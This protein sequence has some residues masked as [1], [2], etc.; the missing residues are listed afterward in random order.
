MTLQ[1]FEPP[2]QDKKK[3]YVI[4]WKYI[5]VQKI[6]ESV[7]NLSAMVGVKWCIRQ[8]WAWH[9]LF[10]QENVQKRFQFQ[11]LDTLYYALQCFLFCI[12]QVIL[13]PT[14]NSSKSAELHQ[15][16][17]PKNSQDSDLKIKLAVRMDKPPHM[18]HSGWVYAWF[19]FSVEILDFILVYHFWKFTER[20]RISDFYMDF[21][22]HPQMT[23]V[24]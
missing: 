16:I 19:F 9:L 22:P 11:L 14:S 7:L 13:Y 6:N 2:G 1:L 3:T 4:I 8:V 12:L 10:K 17:V 18:K 15:M 5:F 24:G 21:Y 20:A 23:Y